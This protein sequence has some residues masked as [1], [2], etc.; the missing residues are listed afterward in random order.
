MNSNLTAN[1]NE[2]SIE[3]V[4]RMINAKT[5]SEPFF[6]NNMSIVNSVTDM[7][8]HPYSRYFRG[9]YYFPEPVIFEREAGWRNTTNSCYTVNGPKIRE[10]KPKHC[11]ETACST[12]FPCHPDY[13]A[14][15]SDQSA[16]DV[17]LENSCISR[18]R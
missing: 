15:Y 18:Y 4:R 10:P 2:H 9:V 16:L 8:H 13:I 1:L 5:S 17:M 11:W 12:T 14:K 3:H 7:D 6:A